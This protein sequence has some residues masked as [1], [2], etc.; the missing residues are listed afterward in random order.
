MFELEHV[1]LDKSASDLLIS[2]RDE[3]LVISW[4]QTRA[5]AINCTQHKDSTTAFKPESF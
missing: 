1:P 5:A 2:P 4:K 3:K